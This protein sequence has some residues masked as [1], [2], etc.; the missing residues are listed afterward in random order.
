M[1]RIG[2]RPINI[3][4]KVKVTINNG[5]VKVEGPKGSLSEDIPDGINVNVENNQI[6]VTRNSD[7]KQIKSLHGLTRVLVSN[8]VTGV[9]EGFT[10]TLRIAGLGYRAQFDN[11]KLTLQLRASHPIVLEVPKG[12]DIAIDRAETIQNQPEIPVRV[13]GID[14]HLVGH[15]SAII[16]DYQRTEPYRGKGIKYAGEHIR[17]KVGK[18]SAG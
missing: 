3:P 4:D 14:K 11:G 1:S 6:L 10:K 17:R 2:R 15:V 13:S 18:T 9:S 7:N 5:N 16:R 8:M 12:I